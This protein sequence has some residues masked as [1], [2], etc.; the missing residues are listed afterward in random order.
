M[1][2]AKLFLI[3]LFCGL[4]VGAAEPVSAQF[5]TLARKI[6]SMNSDGKTVATVIIDANASKVYKAVI[7]T[8]TTQSKFRITK[9]DNGNKH[10]EFTRDESSVTMQ[11][12]S[13]A[14]GYSQITVLAV[15]TESKDPS[16]KTSEAAVKAI[17]T[18]CHKVGIT[19]S[20]KE[21]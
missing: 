6:K 18:V 14:A 5:I 10:V 20:V 12:D 9:R 17:V 19:C 1:K 4:M 13:L 16:K 21:F 7:D 8:L 3:L 11:V 2:R 15:D